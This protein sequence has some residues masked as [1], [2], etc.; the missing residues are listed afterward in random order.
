MK[1]QTKLIS[2]AL[3]CATAVVPTA[4]AFGASAPAVLNGP[5][6]TTRPYVLPIAPGVT[7]ASLLTVGDR[8]AQN[9]YRMVGV[10]DGL[11]AFGDDGVATVLM[12]QEYGATQGT[13]REHGQAGSFVSRYR[14]DLASGEVVAGDDLANNVHYWRYGPGQY[15]AAPTTPFI[16]AFARFCSATLAPAGSLFNAATGNGY[17]EP[18]YLT[19]EE[20]G[21]SGRAF[22]F[23]QAGE[24]WQLPRLGLASWENTTPAPTTTDRTVVL[25]N[26]DGG[27]GQVWAYWGTKTSTGTAVDRAGLTNGTA[28]VLR[29]GDGT[30]T[31]DA[32][33]R[34]TYGKGVSAP[35]SFAPVNWNQSGAAINAEAA[36]NGVSLNRVE[37]GAFDPRQPNDYYFV[38][39]E[40]GDTSVPA[41]APSRD[42]GGLWRLRFVDVNQPELG[43][44]LTLLLDGSEAPYLNKPDNIT[45]DAH[46]NLLVQ[47][48][49]GGNA[50]L[51]RIVA[52]RLED[53]ARGV[54]AQFDPALFTPGAAGFITSDEESSGIIDIS[55]L[56][57]K[58]DT[59]LFDAQ[60]HKNLADPELVQMGQLLTMHVQSWGQVYSQKS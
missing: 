26:E 24:A 12:N 13:V 31:T 20:N 6:T 7:V 39:T 49:P 15:A 28:N 48:D 59:F 42:G 1:R 4:T 38:T 25:G 57:G 54:L 29:V 3:A 2:A 35:V 32:A 56:A 51:A 40:G 33:F 16:A 22:A 27:A 9:G 36:A 43:G 11:G 52:Y 47:E 21:D 14:I 18:L 30:V 37:D 45:L 19:G 53:G 10:P 50:H 17:A 44:S 5:T 23:T 41:G 58:K 46:G 34:A 8:P 55:E 60:V